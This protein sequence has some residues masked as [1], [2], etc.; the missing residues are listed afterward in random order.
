MAKVKKKLSKKAKEALKV[1]EES[2][3][4]GNSKTISGEKP[5]PAFTPNTPSFQNKKAHKAR[6]NKKRG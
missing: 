3:L 1:L 6:P 4:L 5:D 2:K